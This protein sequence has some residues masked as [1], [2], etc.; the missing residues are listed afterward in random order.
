MVGQAGNM[1]VGARVPSRNDQAAAGGGMVPRRRCLLA[2]SWPGNPG[3][4]T[5]AS[6][7]LTPD[8]NSFL[9]LAFKAIRRTTGAELNPKPAFANRSGNK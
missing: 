3:Q 1:G 9:L 6:S 2:G 5:G 4:G 8:V 7:P